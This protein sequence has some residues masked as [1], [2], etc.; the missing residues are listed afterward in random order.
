[1]PLDKWPLTLGRKAAPWP[2]TDPCGTFSFD[3]CPPCLPPHPLPFQAFCAP[4]LPCLLWFNFI[5]HCCT[6]ASFTVWYYNANTQIFTSAYRTAIFLFSLSFPVIFLC[7]L[8]VSFQ[9]TLLLLSAKAHFIY[10]IYFFF[11]F[12]LPFHSHFLLW[13]HSFVLFLKKNKLTFLLQ[14][15]MM[16]WFT[17]T[18]TYM[19]IHA[20][21]LASWCIVNVLV[22]AH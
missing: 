3:L 2:Q 4:S 16:C 11:A 9:C 5:L 1:M 6:E 17:N 12:P 8:I 20:H 7:F 14:W 15:M 10:F 13:T 21:T 22:L 19:H 18:Y